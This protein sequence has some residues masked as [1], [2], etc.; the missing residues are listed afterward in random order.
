MRA[1]MFS[2][3]R[4]L[5]VLG[6]Q[7]VHNMLNQEGHESFLLYLNRFDPDDLKA[8]QNLFEFIREKKPDL[9]ATSLTAVDF[10]L[11]RSITQL[12]REAFPTIPMLW[13]GIH[14]TTAPE[15]CVEHADYVCVGEGDDVITDV[16]RA[17]DAGE[18][19]SGI[20]NLAFMQ[21][22]QMVTNPVRPL[23]ED[24]DRLPIFRQIPPNSFIQVKGHLVPLNAR[25]LARFKVFHGRFYRTIISRGCP[26]NCTYCCNAHLQT[27]YGR[28]AI[29]RRSVE[30]VM[31]ELELALQ[32]GPPVHYITIHDDC[33]LANSL[34]Y[35]REFA[36]EY[37]RRV[38]KPFLAKSTP[39]FLSKTRMDIVVDAG[40]AWIN[41]GL[42]SGSERICNEVYGR[43]MPP[44]LFLKAAQVVKQ[45]SVAA[46][47][48]VIV[49][50]PWETD[51]DVIETINVLAQ[52]PRPYGLLTLSLVFFHGSP[53]RERALRE[54]P[55]RVSDP[56]TKDMYITGKSVLND[57][58]LIASSF[59]R[60]VVNA[61]VNM[62]H[63]KPGSPLTRFIVAALKL[64]HMTILSPITLLRL[65]WL[66]QRKSF[67]KTLTALPT[68][69]DFR[70]ISYFNIF[71]VSKDSTYE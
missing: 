33:F 45:Y 53:L 17:I 5:N 54:M 35:L 13:G 11:A 21:D 23:V 3:Q 36:A 24:L 27:L 9:F 28:T 34:D 37:K 2:I 7:A 59:P 19:L 32:E 26:N 49:D 62:Y 67:F 55:E 51:E 41:V 39:A 15:L 31:Q 66:S 8:N 14:C 4:N 43:T 47:Y 48:D 12:L 16:A 30:H 22:G 64:V 58:C 50:N 25:H 20:A 69:C 68:F 57:I 40:M 65:I 44:S 10:P 52:A 46:H 70:L 1:V 42:E 29:R 60:P 6:L 71:Q 18:S 61:L 38:K 56:I 63:R